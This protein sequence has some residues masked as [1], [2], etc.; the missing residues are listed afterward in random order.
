MYIGVQKMAGY[1]IEQ[2]TNS[3]RAGSISLVASRKTLCQNSE[4]GRRGS[5]GMDGTIILMSCLSYTKRL[6]DR[7][8]IV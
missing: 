5:T 1:E 4:N 6:L 7:P 3:M 8:T 2:G